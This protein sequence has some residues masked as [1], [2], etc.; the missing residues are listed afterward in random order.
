MPIWALAPLVLVA[1][2]ACPVSMWV[3][4]KVM[5]RRMSCPVCAVG[6]QDTVGKHSHDVTSLEARKAARE[7]EIAEVTSKIASEEP[8]SDRARARG[9]GP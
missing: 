6:N 1:L 5:R 9:A 7:R 4:G 8:V 3:M 2:L